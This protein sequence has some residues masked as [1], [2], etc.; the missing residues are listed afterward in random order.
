MGLEEALQTRE[1]RYKARRWDRMF[2]RRTM[3]ASK[4]FASLRTPAAYQVLFRFLAKCQWEP[5]RLSCKREKTWNI[6]NNGSIEFCYSEAARYG[7]S[8]K[9]FARAL[10]ELLRV[11]F[12]DIAHTGYGLHKDKTLYAISDR[13][14]RFG[15]PEF[16]KAERPQRTEKLGFRK[17]NRHG[18]YAKQRGISTVVEGRCATVANDC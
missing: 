11:G 2:V 10:D 5:V 15:T 17:G 16:E 6:V 14:E 13:W 7:I 4:A 12:I 1:Q 18:R 9:R 3:I 8:S